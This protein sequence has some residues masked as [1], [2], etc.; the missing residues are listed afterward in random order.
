MFKHAEAFI[1]WCLGYRFWRFRVIHRRILT[2]GR[3]HVKEKH[4]TLFLP[5]LKDEARAAEIAT[6]RLGS[7]YKVTEARRA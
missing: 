4:I 6:E 7:A 1:L 3:E 2:T 5:V